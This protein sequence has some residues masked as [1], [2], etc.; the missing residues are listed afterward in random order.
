MTY[1]PDISPDMD[2]ILAKLEKKNRQQYVAVMNKLDEILENPHHYKPLGNV[3][4]GR[5]RVHFGSYVLVFSIDEARKKVV[6]KDY[7]HH[8]RV[9]R[10]A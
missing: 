8:D 2:R 6:L 5:R 1:S 4:S 9:Y 3:M 10:K 7:D